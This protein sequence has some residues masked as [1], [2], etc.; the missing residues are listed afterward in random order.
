MIHSKD[1]KQ[2]WLLKTG[3]P[4]FNPQDGILKR[5]FQNKILQLDNF[6][7]IPASR[8]RY[9]KSLFTFNFECFSCILGFLR[10]NLYISEF[11]HISK[12]CSFRFLSLHHFC[13]FSIKNIYFIKTRAPSWAGERIKRGIS[14]R[15]KTI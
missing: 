2:R 13:F 12:F 5:N 1:K 14:N 8:P 6:K 9:L 3:H 4:Y 15:Q 11:K 10:M 7:G